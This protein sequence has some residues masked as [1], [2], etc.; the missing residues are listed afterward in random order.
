VPSLARVMADVD[1]RS[2]VP[3]IAELL[4]IL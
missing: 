2:N 3:A 1:Y 4:S